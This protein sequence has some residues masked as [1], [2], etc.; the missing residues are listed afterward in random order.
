[1][2]SGGPP[3]GPIDFDGIDLIVFDK[4]GTLIDFDV[5]WGGWAETLADR[6]EA[7]T[8]LALRDELHREIG[9][10][11]QARRTQPGSPLAATPMA[12]LRVMTTDFVARST[13]RSRAAAAE[14]VDDAWL[15]PDPVLLAHPLTDLVALLGGLR[16]GSRDG[17]IRDGGP[18][19][20]RGV[21]AGAGAR[22]GAG[23]CGGGRGAFRGD[24]RGG[25][26]NA[27]GGGGRRIAV[28][29][30]DDRAP[31]EAT[32]AGLGIADLVDL[33]VCADDGLPSKPAPDT[34]LEACRGLG[35]S[36]ARTAM[37]G[38]SIADMTMATAA[39]VGLRIAV[40]S[41]IGRRSELEPCSDVILDS[42]AD[43]LPG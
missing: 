27:S 41:G 24:S 32:L 22:A 31:T 25:F 30:S 19:D 7:T 15:A 14:V 11:T 5:M 10:D 39:G 3:S 1:M 4:D 40:L 12:E 28:V 18:G 26:R 8:G 2:S 37:I 35:V 38:D 20:R 34:L 9:Y 13:G 6:L 29:T 36:P 43:L 42:I 21:G 16:G 23:A 33:L 17:G